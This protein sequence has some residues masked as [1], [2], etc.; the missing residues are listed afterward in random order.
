MRSVGLLL[1]MVRFFLFGPNV[2]NGH[3]DVNLQCGTFSA[4]STHRYIMAKDR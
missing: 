1:G 4:M 2:K 3:T